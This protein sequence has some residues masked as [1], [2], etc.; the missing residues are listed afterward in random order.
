VAGFKFRKKLFYGPGSSLAQV[1]ET[2]PD[3][4]HDILARGKVK[5]LLIGRSVLN[6]R[7]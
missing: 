1:V 2:L 4:F 5:H 6:V 7:S 3:S